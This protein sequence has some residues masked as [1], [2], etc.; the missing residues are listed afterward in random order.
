MQPMS[1][2]ISLIVYG[3]AAVYLFCSI[4]IACGE[5]R[6]KPL[7]LPD[8]LPGVS[9]VVCARN[10]E[11]NMR[12]CL[13]NLV[14]IDYPRDRLEIVLV[15][16]ES[17]DATQ[18][19]MREYAGRERTITVLSTVNE[20][21]DL[22]GKQRPL[23]L[24]IRESA[25]EFI[26]ITDADIAVR[27]GW[28]RG[29]LAAY[30]EKIGIA[31]ATTRVNYSSGRFF[32]RL[33]CTELISKHAVAMGCAGLG[34][35]LSIMGNNI[36]FRRNAYESIGGYAGLNCSVVEDMALM[37]AIVTRTGQTLAWAASP[38]SVVT[39]EPEKDLATFVN[40]RYRW[41]YEVTDLS[42]IGKAMLAMEFLMIAA[43]AVSVVIA[44]WNWLPLAVAS[45][46][47]TAGYSALLLAQPG[48]IIMDL[49]YI[50][51]MIV[52]QLFYGVILAR[53]ALSGNRT[54]VW[55]G[56]SYTKQK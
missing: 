30:H 24:G 42:G 50:P 17:T 20:P 49:V 4:V 53:R 22:P 23:N 35:P 52:F 29:H 56:R 45:L 28:V 1:E 44:G 7:P 10:E 12:R 54:M 25:G 43:F 47:W 16:D 48:S 8:N 46:A 2:I 13:D 41:V 38:E 18:A 40:Q 19:I 11:K 9:I 15:D 27:P 36:S 31:G 34:F 39:T 55:K 21:H 6:F 37:N 14:A 51:V 3:Y 32:D 26:L 33:Q 5:R